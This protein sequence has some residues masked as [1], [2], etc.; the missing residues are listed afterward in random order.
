ML[1]ARF[2]G[3]KAGEWVSQFWVAIMLSLPEFGEGHR[4]C[5]YERQPSSQFCQPANL[6][7]MAVNPRPIFD[8]LH[9]ARPAVTNTVDW[10]WATLNTNFSAALFGAL[11][12]AYGAHRIALTKERKKQLTNAIEATNAAIGLSNTIANVYLAV[13]RQHITGLMERYTQQFQELGRVEYEALHGGTPSV[14]TVLAEFRTLTIPDSPIHALEELVA[15][16][17]GPSVHAGSVVQFLKT[18]LEGF[19]ASLIR[20]QEIIRYLSKLSEQEKAL[21]YFGLKYEGNIDENYPD[22][23]MALSAQCDDCIYFSMLLGELLVK[24]GDQLPDMMKRKRPRV[25]RLVYD[26]VPAQ[27]LPD[28]S[29]YIDFERQYRSAT[30]DQGAPSRSRVARLMRWLTLWR[31]LC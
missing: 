24:H 30:A 13:K 26:N 7:D 27:L 10:I 20:R 8:I 18:A 2:K 21:R 3:E 6:R 31:F 23:M 11:A 12:G 15:Q 28:R 22:V 4:L 19:K 17:I 16:R 1:T 29:E 9:A 25:V 14:F 5:L